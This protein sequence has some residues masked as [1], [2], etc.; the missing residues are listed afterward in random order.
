MMLTVVDFYEDASDG[1]TI[2]IDAQ[3]TA[4]IQTLVAVFEK[5]ASRLGE[6]EDLR[7]IQDFKFLSSVS[8]L[9]LKSHSSVSNKKVVQTAP[10]VFEWHGTPEDWEDARDLTIPLV[11]GIPA[12]QYLNNG[13]RDD[14]TIEVA[15]MEP[16]PV[17]LQRVID[18]EKSND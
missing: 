13:L 7:E 4:T 12:H 18:A 8:S 11:H 14:A 3:D 17:W 15:I 1:P 16:R 2:R 6:V 5:L 9:V 10:G